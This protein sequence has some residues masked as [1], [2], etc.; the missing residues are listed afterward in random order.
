MPSW[1]SNPSRPS[2]F[3]SSFGA[4]RPPEPSPSSRSSPASEGWVGD[5]FD[6]FRAG[7]DGANCLIDGRR[8][9]GKSVLAN[10]ISS[11]LLYDPEIRLVK[12]D[13]G[14]SYIKECEPTSRRTCPV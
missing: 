10:L 2:I 5:H 14:G 3:R 6:L 11:S 12:V 13:V 8:G 1:K 7:Y 4:R 9:K